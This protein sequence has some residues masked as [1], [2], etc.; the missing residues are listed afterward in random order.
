MPRSRTTHSPWPRKLRGRCGGRGVAEAEDVATIAVMA[1]SPATA[2]TA[3]PLRLR[4][5]SIGPPVDACAL[6]ARPDDPNP[7]SSPFLGL[8]RSQRHR[9]RDLRSRLD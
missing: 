9:Q 2:A 1:T 8:E 4:F 7:S 6:V 5:Q 3:T